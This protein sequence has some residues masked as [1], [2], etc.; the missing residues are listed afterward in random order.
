MENQLGIDLLLR[1]KWYIEHDGNMTDCPTKPPKDEKDNME[2]HKQ[3]NESLI[4]LDLKDSTP[5]F[6]KNFEGE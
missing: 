6:D 1:M 4:Y 2:A 3:V 5:S